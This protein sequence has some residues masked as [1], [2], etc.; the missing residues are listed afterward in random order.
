MQEA[1]LR[2]YKNY[3]RRVAG[4]LTEQMTEAADCAGISKGFRGRV[5]GHVGTTPGFESRQGTGAVWRPGDRLAGPRR[6][7]SG[8]LTSRA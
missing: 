5:F 2:R 3:T 4:K 6:D 1:K 8:K 7:G